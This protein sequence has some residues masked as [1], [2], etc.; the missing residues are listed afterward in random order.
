MRSRQEILATL[1]ASTLLTT[2][3]LREVARGVT[4]YRRVYQALTKEF[5]EDVLVRINEAGNHGSLDVSFINS[6]LNS[7]SSE[8]RA[9]RAQRTVDIIRQTYPRI[10][11]LE[12]IWV[13]FMSQETH[14][15]IFHRGQMVDY[16]GFHRDGKRFTSQAED[17]PVVSGSSVQSGVTVSYSRATR[18]SDVLV[19]GIQLADEPGNL[20]ITV[21]PHYT[22]LGDVRA[23]KAR[24]PEVVAFDFTVY[25]ETPSV[26]Q[27]V[28]ITFLADKKPVLQRN[29]DFYGEV[30]KSCPLLIPYAAFS[31]MIA[32]R[33]LTIK[34][35]DKEYPLKPAE[36]AAI[37]RMGDYVQ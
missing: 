11:S 14:Y 1:V 26:R 36:F 16:F 37:Q 23:A 32:A 18:Q 29:A 31:K 5:G 13:I 19:N 2:A 35:G 4:E 34:V 3:C 10:D 24:P 8:E 25:T 9:A 6:A 7:R 30:M 15:V 21:V 28:P 33:E 17:R 22:V 12:V 27:T 20:R